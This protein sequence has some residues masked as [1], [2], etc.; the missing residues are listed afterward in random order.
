M[1]DPD[2]GLVAVD[3]DPRPAV[4][5]AIAT[6]P[7][8]LR[9]G[10]HLLRRRCRAGRGGGA[11]P[12]DRR[13]TDPASRSRS[14]TAASRTTGTSSRPSSGGAASPGRPSRPTRSRAAATPRCAA[15]TDPVALLA[16]PIGDSGLPAPRRSVGWVRGSAI[17][18]GPRPPVPPA[19][20]LR[21]PAR[22]ARRSPSSWA[23]RT[24][25]RS[26]ARVT[27]RSIRVEQTFRRRDPADD[28]DRRRRDRRGRGGLVRPALHRAS[29]RGGRPA[30]RQR[31][32]QEARL[33]GDLRR[34]G[35][36]ARRRRGRL[37]HAGR[38]VPVYRLTA[39]LTAPRLRVAMREALDR[40]GRAYPEYLPARSARAEESLAGIGRALEAAH[41]PTDLEARDAALRRLAF[42]ELLAL[43]L[44]MVGRRRERGPLA[45]RRS[46]R[47]RRRA[48]R[49]R[50]GRRSP[51]ALVGEARPAGRR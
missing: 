29:A 50:S 1:L 38:I 25:T 32:A 37:L 11:R 3:G 49:W 30:R 44:G 35:V 15:P 26:S 17:A 45:R 21:R 14:G 2:D 46:A 8:G 24:A 19:A 27:V 9:A 12:P 13:A 7:P 34:P 36:P 31:P 39:G 33:R 28:R 6:L 10:H 41:Y 18:H 48:R 40:A 43:Q 51:T 23:A 4:L 20:P 16:T 42:D 47:R 5:A 22:D